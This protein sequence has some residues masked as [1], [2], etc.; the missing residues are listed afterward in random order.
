MKVRAS[1]PQR[2]S[3]APCSQWPGVTLPK[4]VDDALE[5]DALRLSKTQLQDEY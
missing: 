4:G 3:Q 2:A 1:M 5:E